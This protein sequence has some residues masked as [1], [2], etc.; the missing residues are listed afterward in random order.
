MNDY[1]WIVKLVALTLVLGRF[2]ILNAKN[3]IIYAFGVTAIAA[4]APEKARQ[5]PEFVIAASTAAFAGYLLTNSIAA[6]VKNPGA[7]GFKPNWN[8]MWHYYA[9]PFLSMLT[10]SIIFFSLMLNGW[11]AL[12]ISFIIVAIFD[13]ANAYKCSSP[14]PPNQ[15]L[16]ATALI[17][18][19]I[20]ALAMKKYAVIFESLR[21]SAIYISLL[22]AY[23]MIKSTYTRPYKINQLTAGM[24]PAESVV[25]KN[26]L[27]QRYS[28]PFTIYAA[29]R[30]ALFPGSKTEEIATP[31]KQLDSKSISALKSAQREH[32]VSEILIQRTVN[33]RAFLVFGL[34]VA[35]IAVFV[36]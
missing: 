23:H 12:I 31:F 4:Y 33:F 5:L 18:V 29:L 10:V 15:F 14:H 19:F 30:A 24:L 21:V 13:A 35:C 34:A 7:I 6:H 26:G 3:A 1:L 25:L 36:Y 9:N 20:A 28:S 17:S 8:R 22:W 16:H 2:K 32:E 27:I 11:I